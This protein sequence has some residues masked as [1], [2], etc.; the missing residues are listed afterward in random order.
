MR[1]GCAFALSLMSTVMMLVLPVCLRAADAGAQSDAELA[2]IQGLWERRTGHDVPGLARATK[3]IRGNHERI[4]YYGKDD[5]VIGGHEVD[6]KLQQVDGIKIFTY[7]NWV[8][9]AGSDK[10]RKSS[11]QVSYIYRVDEN[12]YIEVWGFMPRQEKRPPLVMI[13]VRHPELPE[14]DRRQLDELQGGWQPTRSEQGSPSAVDVIGS[15]IQFSGQEFR[16]IHD[17]RRF[18][19]GAVR[20]H[21]EQTPARID[22]VITESPNGM[23]NG[24][25]VRGVYAMSDGALKLCFASPADPRP[26]K[27]DVIHGSQQ[28]VVTL[29]KGSQ[30]AK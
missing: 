26:Q 24:Q 29:K 22:L 15:E 9:T 30:I 23:W 21:P 14:A 1:A 5:Q 18:V 7:Y 8:S 27:L 16:T 17:G 4:T 13:W 10:G 20:V 12:T 6:F 2:K 3:E 11:E 25:T 28:T 19:S